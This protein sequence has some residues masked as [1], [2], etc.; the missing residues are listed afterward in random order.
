MNQLGNV[1]NRS[2]SLPTLTRAVVF[3]LS[4]IELCD[5]LA[6]APQQGEGV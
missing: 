5:M 6:K 2:E 4:T 1:K 3:C